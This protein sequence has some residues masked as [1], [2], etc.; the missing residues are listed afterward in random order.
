[1]GGECLAAT[2]A[3]RE[4][5]ELDDRLKLAPFKDD[6]DV[7]LVDS[8]MSH[9]SSFVQDESGAVNAGIPDPSSVEADI[10]RLDDWVAV[11]RKRGRT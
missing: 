5:E 1:V 7:Q 9:C 2:Q 3:T 6:E 4:F 11:L 10:K 8:E